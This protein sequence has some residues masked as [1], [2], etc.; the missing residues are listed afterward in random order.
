M[1]YAVSI[2]VILLAA[3]IRLALNPVLSDRHPYTFFFAGIAVTA[4]YAGFWPSVLAIVLAYALADWFFVTPHFELDLMNYALNDFIGL[5]GF[6]CSGFAIAFT[7]KALH[8]AKQRAEARQRELAQEIL[9]R[10]R[11]AAELRVAKA[12]LEEQAALLE[13]RVEERTA[14]LLTTIQSLEGVCYHLAH[15][16]RAPLRAMHGYADIVLGESAGRL[17]GVG[18]DH[19]QRL[20][21]ASQRMDTL[22]CCLIEY[23]RIGHEQFVWQSVDLEGEISSV[24]SELA[25][26]I[27]QSRAEISVERPLP[28]IWGSRTLVRQILIQLTDNGLKFVAP[29]GKPR[30]NFRAKAGKSTMR[31]WVSDNGIGIAPEHHEKIFGIFERLYPGNAYPGTGIGLAIVAKAAQRM[32]GRVGV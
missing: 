16:L 19:L 6:L 30:L 28:R 5:G 11:I 32:G 21:A 23:G 22:L 24:L 20:C 26:L 1:P 18:R 25:D 3:A 17:G 15:D 8:T 31:L 4:W 12:Q 13:Q 9:E 29:G 10:E 2:S 27:Q 7:S 14:S